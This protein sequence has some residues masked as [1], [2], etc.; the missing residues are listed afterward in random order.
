MNIGQRQ[1]TESSLSKQGQGNT[2][3]GLGET[4]KNSLATKKG[5]FWQT[6][7][8]DK[9]GFKPPKVRRKK[10]QEKYIWCLR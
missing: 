1:T 7:K 4:T 9:I 5:C 3:G 8:R 10:C 2:F 6:R